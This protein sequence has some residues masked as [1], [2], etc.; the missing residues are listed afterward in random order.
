MTYLLAGVLGFIG[1]PFLL[2]LISRHDKRRINKLKDQY[3][4][5]RK[6]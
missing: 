4:A 6:K 2:F 3:G 5:V 1:F